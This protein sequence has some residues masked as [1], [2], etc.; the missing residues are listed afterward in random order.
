MTL[1][2]ERYDDRILGTLSCW[3]RVI[4]TGTLPDLCY[5]QAM[6]KTL[7]DKG[8][9]LFDYTKFTEPLR[10]EIR[11]NTE[12]LAAEHGLTIEYIQKRNFRKEDRIQKILD[13]RGR[14]P[15]LVHIFSAMEPCASFRPWHDK[16]THQTFLKPREAK[17]LHYYFY[18]IDKDLGPC[19]LRVPT[20]APFRLQFYFNG[21]A[22][23]AAQMDKKGMAYTLVDNAFTHITSFPRAQKIVDRFSERTLHRILDRYARQYC[24]VVQQFSAGIHWSLMQIEYATDIVFRRKQDLQ[25]LYDSW[26]RTVVHAVKAEQ[27]ATFLGRKLDPRFTGEVGNDF[28]TRIEGTRI[29]HHM[30]PASIKMYD[31]LGR[32]LRIETTANRVNFFKHH[33]KVEHR[34]GTRSMKT[35]PVLKSIYSMG[36]LSELLG[37][38]NRRYLTFLS[39]L[40]Q[41]D[42]GIRAVEKIAR[43]ACHDERSY[44]GF[45]LFHGEDLNLLIAIVRGEFAISG[46][47]NRDLQTCLGKTGGQVSRMLKRLRLHGVIKKIGNTYKYYLTRF[48]QAVVAC[49]LRLRDSIVL[50]T[51]G[52]TE[53]V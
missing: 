49:A 45:N 9:R 23:L 28:N 48:G 15:G 29:R 26:V 27:V 19:Y 24:P 32:V 52:E 5:A 53:L 43:P 1:L 18:F 37:A 33:R 41:P 31:K 7:T 17:C 21:H 38:S 34:D 39:A 36:V 13:Q 10:N 12:R 20:W 40:D 35:A 11:C 47:R 4:I 46:L 16:Q 8:I 42:V 44:R 6:A 3:D 51:L 50:P 22:W 25:P 2:E 14:H 30:G